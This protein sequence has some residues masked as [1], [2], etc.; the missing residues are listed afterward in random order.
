MGPTAPWRGVECAVGLC[1]S[2]AAVWRRAVANK[3]LEV[4]PYQGRHKRNFFPVAHT[5][6]L[7][8]GIVGGYLTS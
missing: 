6:F 4:A 8:S 3:S 5:F 2:P 1:R 7:V